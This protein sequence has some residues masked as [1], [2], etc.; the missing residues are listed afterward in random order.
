MGDVGDGFV[1]NGCSSAAD[2]DDADPCTT[3]TCP[4]A[5][6]MCAHAAK[7]CSIVSDACNDGM[8]EAGTGTCKPTPANEGM[9]CG[10]GTT[11]G[12]CTG[13]ACTPLPT[14]TIVDYLSCGDP[15]SSATTVGTINSVSM[16]SCNGATNETGGEYVYDFYA[17]K[18]GMVTLTLSNTSADLDIIVLD[19]SCNSAAT[20]TASATT[21]SGNDTVS[22]NAVANTDY[23]I[24]IDGKNGV[25]SDFTLTM[26]CAKSCIPE[27]MA[28]SCGDVVSGTTI[29]GMSLQTTNDCTPTGVTNPGPERS[30]I[31]T[32]PKDTEFRLN[33]KN[34][35]VD[36][37][38]SV[39]DSNT[40]TDCDSY[41]ETYSMGYNTG[42]A[43]ETV[44][45][46]AYSTYTYYVVVDSKDPTGGPFT[47]EVLCP[48]NCALNN[49]TMDCT[50][51]GDIT[52]NDNATYSTNNINS[53]GTG[54]TMASNT[55][56]PE[57]VYAFYPPT[58][59]SYTFT[60]SG[61]AA[62]LDLI[63]IENAAGTCDPTMAVKAV[64]TNPGTTGE[65]IT[66][67]LDP[68]NYY[69]LA[70]DGVA[71]AV[72][73]YK[74][75]VTSTQC[76]AP[77]CTNY[78]NSLT[79]SYLQETRRNDDLNRST[80]F[81]DNWCMGSANGLTNTTGPEVVYTFDPPANGSYT[82]TLKNMSANLDLAVLQDSTSSCNP[83]MGCVASSHNT[84]TTNE[85][86]TF[87]AS[88]THTY[89]I[90]VDGVAGATSSYDINL[91]TTMAECPNVPICE[92]SGSGL[93]CSLASTSVSGS[94]DAYGSTS[95]V[96]TWGT[97]T[98]CDT[99]TI[100][101]EYAYTFTP[102][103]T[104]S[105]TFQLI[106]LKANLDLI[107]TA[108]DASGNC[109]AKATT[110]VA[111][112]TATG[113]TSE[114]VTVNLT[115]GQLYYIVVDGVAGAISPYTLAVTGGCP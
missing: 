46:T 77:D 99:N 43:D 87:T 57:V 111:A 89:Y 101:P 49:K 95:T 85:S 51:P 34:L 25:S 113:T 108:A 5:T 35:T 73:S 78:N 98:A 27:V 100:G 1:M 21:T 91:T 44:S 45:F 33:L 10:S 48:P 72:S 18:S 41:C 94:N 75:S 42:T 96:S 82:V 4:S 17:T 26:D 55:T 15:P 37:D 70:V 8:C 61:L 13:G 6:K 83:T 50:N 40:G 88:T 86:I 56:G 106:G 93:S 105:Y 74:L 16:Y 92:D 54:T 53:W 3:D 90:V 64:S 97:T 110:C 114:S 84:N 36:Q 104:A 102:P 14:C 32:V 30:Y 7:N 71:G 12:T 60:L 112:G 79:C 69:Y 19:G 59:G 66:A 115:S 2:C 103:A 11:A 39:L 28:L 29:G 47:L 81:V 38:L 9:A 22:F 24:V 23:T 76:G 62:N 58:A 107:I 80:G 65:T 31:I 68:A 63:L 20:C 109:N 67:T 52:T